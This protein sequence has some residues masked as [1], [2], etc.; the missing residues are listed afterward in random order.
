MSRQHHD[1]F[2]GASVSRAGTRDAPSSRPD[3]GFAGQLRDV[4]LR[5]TAP[6]LAV[7]AAVAEHQHAD[8]DTLVTVVR[9]RLGTVS[10][11][12]VYDVLRALT[13]TGLV[14]RITLDERRARYEIH[15]HDNHHHVM[16]RACGGIHDVP[17]RVGSA[18][19][20][21]PPEHALDGMPFRVDEADVVYLGLCGDCEEPLGA[22]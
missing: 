14:R 10:K 15:R 8:A 16:C 6:R 19:C 18:P 13:T 7:L 1:P 22:A 9:A 3:A 4:G 17:C 21:E 2:I 12:A 11:Q 5:V 20:L